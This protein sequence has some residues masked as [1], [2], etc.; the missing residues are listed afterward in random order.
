L[1]L[2]SEQKHGLPLEGQVFIGFTRFTDSDQSKRTLSVQNIVQMP[3]SSRKSRTIKYP[4]NEHSQ[5]K[6]LFVQMPHSSRDFTN[7]KKRSKMA[8]I[9]RITKKMEDQNFIFGT[10]FD[11]RGT[12]GLRDLFT[13]SKSCTQST[14]FKKVRSSVIDVHARA[15]ERTTTES[16]AGTTSAA[17]VEVPRLLLGLFSIGHFGVVVFPTHRLAS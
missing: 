17:V 11:K 6:I 10:F 4:I 2:R 15:A 1:L 16:A 3:H 12:L 13:R 7:A 9:R 5:F 8:L 14:R